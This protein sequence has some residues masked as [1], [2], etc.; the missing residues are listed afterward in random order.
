MERCLR[1]SGRVQG[2]GFRF[3]ASR[4]ARSIGEISGYACNLPDG[5]VVVL[6]SG[7][8]TKLNQM[9]AHLYKGPLFARVDKIEETP[10]LKSYLPPIEKNVF[11]RI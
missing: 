9:Q 1:I 6:M 8:E 10:E 5:D 7:E 3:W 11:K 4:L 2:V